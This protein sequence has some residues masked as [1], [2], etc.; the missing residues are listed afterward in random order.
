MSDIVV[1]PIETEAERLGRAYVWWQAWNEAYEG[2]VSADYLASRSLPIYEK[3]AMYDVT[4]VIVAKDGEQVVGFAKYGPCCD[5]DMPDAGEVYQLYVLADWYRQGIGSRLM[6]KAQR[7]L[8]S[9]GFD[10]IVLWVLEKNERAISF[11]ERCGFISDGHVQDMPT[12]GDGVTA[13]R[14]VLTSS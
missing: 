3:R 6:R 5:D 4:G 9:D 14:M 8:S 13:K 11:Y 12:L 2:I 7:Q 10:T 1:K